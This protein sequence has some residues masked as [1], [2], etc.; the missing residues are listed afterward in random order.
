MNIKSLVLFTLITIPFSAFANS[1]YENQFQDTQGIK[2]NCADSSYGQSVECYSGIEK[3]L[4]NIA[5]SIKGSSLK[6]N[7]IAEW[8]K[9]DS[10]IN[11]VYQLCNKIGAIESPLGGVDALS[12]VASCR[13]DIVA[14]K[15]YKAAQIF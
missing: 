15:P 10:H 11:S 2:Y 13:V 8:N 9:T 3:K 6:K 7:K 4:T 14:L 5:N 1:K 12:T